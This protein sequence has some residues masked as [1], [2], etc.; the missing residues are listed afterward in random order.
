M[1]NWRIRFRTSYSKSWIKSIQKKLEIMTQKYLGGT[2]KNWICLPRIIGKLG[3]SRVFVDFD[4][5]SQTLIF[6]NFSFVAPKDP[7]NACFTD[8]KF[9][10]R[11]TFFYNSLGIRLCYWPTQTPRQKFTNGFLRLSAQEIGS[12]LV[13][14]V[15]FLNL[16][17]LSYLDSSFIRWV[18][19]S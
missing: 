2:L 11:P 12:S 13:S 14:L 10:H 15:S 6:Y 1:W 5:I 17:E 4:E 9:F 8:H 19:K 3:S 18:R 7:C 16:Y